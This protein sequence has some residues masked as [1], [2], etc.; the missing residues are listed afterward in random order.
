MYFQCNFEN[1]PWEE[2]L[3]DS[4]YGAQS[5][6][7]EPQRQN[8]QVPQAPLGV[9]QSFG[10]PK[11]GYI[12]AIRK[13]SSLCHDFTPEESDDEV[14]DGA[15]VPRRSVHLERPCRKPGGPNGES[16]RLSLGK[17]TSTK[18]ARFLPF[19]FSCLGGRSIMDPSGNFEGGGLTIAEKA[20]Q[21][22]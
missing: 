11:E 18:S 2:K 15:Q 13:D 8:K 12:E 19:C 22:P 17:D 3:K 21:T 6:L 20:D 4:S 7:G 9:P 1:T 5:P 14:R 16:A 10:N